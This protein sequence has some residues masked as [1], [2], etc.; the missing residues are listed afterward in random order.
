MDT[1]R[2]AAL[3]RELEGYERYGKEER[4]DEVRA[5]LARLRGDDTRK[6]GR[7]GATEVET[8][9]AEPPESR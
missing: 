5:E 2:I 9:A 8:T 6:R 3:E 7:R 1:D 4:A